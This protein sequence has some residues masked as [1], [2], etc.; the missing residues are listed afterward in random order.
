L[1]SAGAWKVTEKINGWLNKTTVCQHKEISW[2]YGIFLKAR[3]RSYFLIGK[4]STLDLSRPDYVINRKD[5]DEI[6]KKLMNIPYAE[7]KRRGFSKGT[8]HYMKKNAKVDQSFYLQKQ[9]M[10]RLDQ[11]DQAADQAG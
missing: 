2:D 10:T 5:A 7:W 11:W 4:Q 8:L 1:K 3:E 6:R 9:V